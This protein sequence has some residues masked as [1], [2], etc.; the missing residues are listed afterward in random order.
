MASDIGIP[1]ASISSF[2]GVVWPPCLQVL[3][4]QNRR[5]DLE[6][7]AALVKTVGLHGVSRSCIDSVA[8]FFRSLMMA[9]KMASGRGGQPGM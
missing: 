5:Y 4:G 8:T 3:T 1:I 7:V 9:S 2:G 6:I